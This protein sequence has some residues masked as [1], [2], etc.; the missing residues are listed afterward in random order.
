MIVIQLIEVQF[1]AHSLQIHCFELFRPLSFSFLGLR[2]KMCPT[3][4]I[5]IELLLLLL[6]L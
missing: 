5:I 2:I 6:L 4:V 1:L 3:I